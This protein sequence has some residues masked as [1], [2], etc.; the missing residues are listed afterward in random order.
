MVVFVAKVFRHKGK[1]GNLN[2]ELVADK[3][4]HKDSTPSTYYHFICVRLYPNAN[5]QWL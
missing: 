3:S 5:C 1:A 2:F 4:R